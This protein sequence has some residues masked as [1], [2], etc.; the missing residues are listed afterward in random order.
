MLPHDAR[1]N[2]TM[3]EC[4]S[5]PEVMLRTLP[6]N[7]NLFYNN[8]M[9]KSYSTS[10][11]S[12]RNHSQFQH[13]QPPMKAQKRARSIKYTFPSNNKPR[14]SVT[15]SSFA[16]VAV[17]EI[18][19]EE[20]HECW[21]QPNEYV[22]IQEDRK[23]CLDTVKRAMLGRAP[24]PDSSEF[25]LR[26]LEQR[27]S[28]KQVFERKIKNMQYRRLLLEEQHVQRCCGVSDPK[29]LQSL[30]ELFTQQA[31]QRALRRASMVA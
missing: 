2:L 23:R 25:C 9:G 24:V 6:H 28:T 4:F 18:S 21:I 14:K 13:V 8:A 19:R 22:Q 12:L 20:L 17:R 27:L 11:M 16:N 29:A 15:F 3:N 26:G 10:Q 5:T 1:Y 7:H 31:T 30:S